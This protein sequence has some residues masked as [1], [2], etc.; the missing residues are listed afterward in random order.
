MLPP[1]EHVKL[2]GVA[3][4]SPPGGTWLHYGNP[5]GEYGFLTHSVGL[6]DF[7]HRGRLCLVGADRQ[8]FL[9]GQVTN[10]LA[11]LKPG[12]GCHAA[13]VGPKAKMDSDLN[14]H[15]LKDEILLDFEPGL[16]AKVESRI[17]RYII[18]ED[19]QIVDASGFYGMFS[20]QGPAALKVMESIGAPIGT[21]PQSHDCAPF[22]SE[23]FGEA[24]LTRMGRLGG[25]GFDLYV[26]GDKLVEAWR[27]LVELAKDQGGGPAGWE[28]FECARIEMGIPRFGQDMDSATMPPE[29]GLQAR[30]ISYN[31]G[32]YIGQEI[33][34]RIRTYGQ[35]A[36]SLK[37]LAIN[38]PESA[39]PS[40]L[41]GGKLTR[42]G[43]EVGWITSAC[44]SPKQGAVLGLGYVRRGSGESGTV[45]DLATGGT[46]E[47]VGPPWASEA[48]AN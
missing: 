24:Y 40:Q 7:T 32:C 35:V 18:A 26:P 8:R 3:A 30:A 5:I 42:N 28:A 36:K 4:P 2:G 17:G 10:Q 31:K 25:E 15:L 12:Q 20:L 11:H 22:Q 9:N 38:V 23:N 1:A 47:V 39:D 13:L 6:L 34:A 29:A 37:R 16:S 44:R 48:A 27:R 21:V 14:I 41:A 43:K 45:L 19:V 33:I 46:V